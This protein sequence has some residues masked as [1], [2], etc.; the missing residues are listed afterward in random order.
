M[1]F[2]IDQLIFTP[3]D[4]DL[5]YSPLQN[6]GAA[7]YVLGAFNPG[8][9]R[10][11]N[12][13]LIMM[14]RVAEAL[15]EPIKE[16]LVRQIRWTKEGYQLD[17]FPEEAI[18]TT[19]PRKFLFK[20]YKHIETY[21]L[22][23]LSWILPIELSPEGTKIIQIHYDKIIAP[24]REFQEFGI[25]DARISLIEGIYYMTTCSVSAQRHSTTLYTSKNGIDYVLDGIILDHQ[26]K[27]MLF[28]E[29]KIG[30]QFYAMTR[31]LGELYF[32]YAATSPFLPGPSINL[33][34]SPDGLHWKPTD[35]PFLR[36]QKGTS[37]NEKI[38]GGAPPI[39]TPEGWLVLY[40]GVEKTDHV[41]IYRTFWA[42]L[43]KED[44]HKIL[45]QEDSVPLLEAKPR[46]TNSLKEQIYINDVVFTTGIVANDANYIVASGELDLCCR[47]TYIPKT[48]FQ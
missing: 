35:Y 19:D 42:L 38:G 47:I 6:L 11:P 2:E 12:G 13:N 44:P 46:F 7:T 30:A 3:N 23:S 22:S 8:L 33:A 48:Y 28:F 20:E 40:H 10:L 31:P 27:D 14:V 34:A 24:S 37:S 1:D 4:V 36:A 18:D 39:L 41:G 25:E 45:R 17:E 15:E 32:G 21:A 16:G 5:A 9:N 26:N 43:D 29:G